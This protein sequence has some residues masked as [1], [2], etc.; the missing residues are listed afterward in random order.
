MEGWIFV[1]QRAKNET[2]SGTP[3]IK[4]R[5]V[6]KLGFEISHHTQFLLPSF[7]QIG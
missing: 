4:V 7:R 5:E 3:K 6:I 2:F 1:A